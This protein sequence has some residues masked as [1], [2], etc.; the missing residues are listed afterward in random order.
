MY[1]ASVMIAAA[2]IYLIGFNQAHASY[3][4]IRWSSGYCQIW[5]AASPGK[6]FPGDYKTGRK[7]FRTFAEA[8]VARAR[9]IAQRQCY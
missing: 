9:L 5:D 8:T 2:V 6:P 3:Q 7:T 1:R 4:I